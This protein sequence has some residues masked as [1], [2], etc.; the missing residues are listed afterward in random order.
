MEYRRITAEEA[1]QAAHFAVRGMRPT[2]YPL[3]LSME[4]VRAMVKHFTKSESD[5]HLAAFD[6]GVM[7]GGIAVLRQEL[8][9]FVYQEAIVVMLFATKPPAGFHLLRAALRWFNDDPFMRRLAWALEFDV[10]PRM[11]R[12]GERLGFNSSNVTLHKYKV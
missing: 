11:L 5:F 4:K 7:V 1:D 2:L 8:P 12:I 9:W 10:E 6:E 3:D